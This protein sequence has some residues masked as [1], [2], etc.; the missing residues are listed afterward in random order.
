MDNMKTNMEEVN[1]LMQIHT[2][3]TGT[4]RGRRYAVEILNKSAI[5]LITACWEALAEDLA[6]E[7]FDFILNKAKSPDAF[8]KKVRAFAS[9]KLKSDNDELKV[10]NLAGDG[11]KDVLSAHRDSTLEKIVGSLNTPRAENIDRMF[12]EVLGIP[13]V[14][15]SWTWGKLSSEQAREKLSDF[16]TLRGAIAHRVTTAGAVTKATVLSYRDFAYRLGVKTSNRVNTHIHDL[17]GERP[18][19]RWRFGGVS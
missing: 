2:T 1:R 16:V 10:W 13:K 6:S 5:V 8:P 11:W 18:W 9:R 12:L 7:G 14:S 19:A 17:V 3:L 15:S 4:G